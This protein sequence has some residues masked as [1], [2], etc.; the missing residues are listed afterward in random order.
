MLDDGRVPPSGLWKT[1][2]FCAVSGMSIITPSRAISRQF[3]SQAPG[4]PALAGHGHRFE[5]RLHGFFTQPGR[6]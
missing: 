4:L 6:A 2:R 3:R 1:A 5:Q